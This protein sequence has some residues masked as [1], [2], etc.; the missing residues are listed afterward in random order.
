VIIIC[1]Y[2]LKITNETTE[3]SIP[4]GGDER[5][6]Q[7][8]QKRSECQARRFATMAHNANTR[9]VPS[10]YI[11][12]GNVIPYLNDLQI[13]SSSSFH[14][15][16]YVRIQPRELENEERAEWRQNTLFL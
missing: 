6:F 2:S 9:R 13:E 8:L 5:R 12:D 4:N 3:R 1:G 10:D 7:V 11:W 16:R 15:N 14:P